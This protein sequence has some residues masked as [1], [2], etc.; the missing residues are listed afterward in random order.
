MPDPILP[1]DYTRYVKLE[2]IN[3]QCVQLILFNI[4]SSWNTSVF[5]FEFVNSIFF[6]KKGRHK[7][8]LIPNYHLAIRKIYN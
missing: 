7:Q 6:N 4:R 1:E 3:L 8:P 5:L 2:V